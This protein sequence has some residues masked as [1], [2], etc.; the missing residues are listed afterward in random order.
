MH[1]AFPRWF[2][3]LKVEPAD[4]ATQLSWVEVEK[5][6]VQA[7]PPPARERRLE[8][9]RQALGLPATTASGGAGRR[10]RADVQFQAGCALMLLLDRSS[11]LDPALAYALICASY[12]PGAQPLVPPLLPRARRWLSDG[13]IQ[14]RLLDTSK[15]DKALPWR[16]PVEYATYLKKLVE[17]SSQDITIPPSNQTLTIKSSSI[18]EEILKKLCDDIFSSFEDVKTVTGTAYKGLQAEL[19]R[20]TEHVDLQSWAQAAYSSMLQTPL[21]SL[22]MAPRCVMAGLE[23]ARITR[24]SLGPFHA[25]GILYQALGAPAAPGTDEEVTLREA[26]DGL[27][28][29]VRH[30]LAEPPATD[31]CPV[32][33]TLVVTEHALDPV[34]KQRVHPLRLALQVYEEELLNR[35]LTESRS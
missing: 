15:E 28:S 20:L 11:A 7:A 30:A 35:L 25:P 1:T 8:L 18:K 31:L 19:N 16:P 29:S 21:R 13:A 26:L 2:Q 22:S 4:E 6:V 3:V 24:F 12:D 14:C 33:R 17:Q 32:Y 27:P 34:L 10:P 23:L 5:L 9:V